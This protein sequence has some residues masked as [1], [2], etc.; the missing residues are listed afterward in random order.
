V[1]HAAISSQNPAAEL[2]RMVSSFRFDLWASARANLP[3]VTN[4]ASLSMRGGGWFR[5]RVDVCGKYL[6]R[7]R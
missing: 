4:G 7:E 3:S 6:W 2:R 1:M 5:K